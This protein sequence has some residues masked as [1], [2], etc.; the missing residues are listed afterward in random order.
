MRGPAVR[1]IIIAAGGTGGH[2]FPA[3]ALAAT[4]IA[5]GNRVV[6]MTDGRSG[7]AQKCYLCRARTACSERRRHRRTWGVA[8]TSRSGC[9]IAA[10]TAQARRLLRQLDASVLVGFGGYPSVPPILAARLLGRKPAIIL[11]EQNA[12]L[13]RANRF[14]SRFADVLALG[15]ADTAKLPS[16]T[17][18]DVC[19]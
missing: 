16:G 3:E 12:V 4:L 7:C 6:L 11:H 9:R 1:P 5:R 14:L 8:R 13:G 10:G 18:A 17:S 15:F 19:R 2:F